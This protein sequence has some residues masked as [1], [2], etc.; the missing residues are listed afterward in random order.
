MH[1]HGVG[2]VSSPIV[3]SDDE[4]ECLVEN[5]LEDRLSDRQDAPEGPVEP[6]DY[7]EESDFR[8]QAQ[9]SDRHSEATEVNDFLKKGPR[10]RGDRKRKRAQE[11]P[12][13]MSEQYQH[14]PKVALG[15]PNP[16]KK[17]K[18]VGVLRENGGVE[19]KQAKKRRRKRER[20]KVEATAALTAAA[21]RLPARL[22]SPRHHTPPPYH[23][24]ASTSRIPAKPPSRIRSHSIAEPARPLSP[25]A[26]PSNR[27]TLHPIHSLHHDYAFPPPPAPLP[28]IH[29]PILPDFIPPYAPPLPTMS[30]AVGGFSRSLNPLPLLPS[31]SFAEARSHEPLPT[32][33][34]QAS[35]SSI[36]R[37]V[38]KKII[39]MTADPED[40]K[41]HGIFSDSVAQ[42][43]PLDRTLVLECLPKKLRTVEFVQTWA[44]Y[45]GSN[46]VE[47]NAKGKALVVF[48]DPQVA[49]EAWSSPRLPIDDGR[50][51]I[52]AYWYRV[53]GDFEEGEIEEWEVEGIN[54]LQ[55]K[56][57]QPR[58]PPLKGSGKKKGSNKRDATAPKPVPSF[59]GPKFAAYASSPAK[60][61][62]SRMAYFLPSNYHRSPPIF[63]SPVGRVVDLIDDAMDIGS[64]DGYGLPPPF[65]NEPSSLNTT[66]AD[67]ISLS[68][69]ETQSYAASPE[70]G[71]SNLQGES[72]HPDDVI[73]ED[74][75]H[76]DDLIPPLRTLASFLPGF[77]DPSPSPDDAL[78]THRTLASF[79]PDF[80]DP[81]PSPPTTP[82][83]II[84]SSP[85]VES[86]LTTSSVD[87]LLPKPSATLL[88]RQKMLEEKIARGRKE[89]AARSVTQPSTD[90]SIPIATTDNTQ[91][92]GGS[93]SSVVFGVSRSKDNTASNAAADMSA[94]RQLVQASKKTKGII[95]GC[96][97]DP[98]PN[99]ENNTPSLPIKLSTPPP[100]EPSPPPPTSATSQTANLEDL[101]TSFIAASIQSVVTT[102]SLPLSLPANPPSMTP[103]AVLA[104]KQAALDKHISE[105]KQLMTKLST[106]KTKAEKD[107]IMAELRASS[108]RAEDAMKAYSTAAAMPSEDK[109]PL[110]PRKTT[111][112]NTKE[113]FVLELSDDEDEE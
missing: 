77:Q 103:K 91:T 67:A 40:L 95:R 105:S 44:S 81:E 86:H 41:G 48:G 9:V 75:A 88:A 99:S 74:L 76:S 107:V 35:S 78:G 94:L 37:N 83:A 111:W 108:R 12:E 2:S 33:A 52:R 109:R 98:A 60:I 10:M 19:S 21:P 80:Q 106:A 65:D 66:R 30:S 32:S 1:W 64:D 51:H 29:F 16:K 38:V 17:Q 110:F 101:A 54:K 96:A 18:M 28:P 72:V 56:T 58:P 89:I 46:H 3:I 13:S 8:D 20:A 47:I 49:R 26:D 39:G 14:V 82:D 63:A 71:A 59:H 113:M 57:T 79:L 43:P 73:P 62:P 50:E 69:S 100:R 6:F 36:P 61:H 87:A 55:A 5:A 85:P 112:P 68:F 23:P 70:T 102:P 15:V 7:G 53:T 31:M 92:A 24:I 25:Q 104:A 34:S 4:D 27:P 42:S 84:L 22:P 45:F 11:L 90:V 93:S 97:L